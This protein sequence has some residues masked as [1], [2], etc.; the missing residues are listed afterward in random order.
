M[1]TLPHISPPDSPQVLGGTSRG[2]GPHAGLGHG[3]LGD[4]GARARLW[5]ARE[6]AQLGADARPPELFFRDSVGAWHSPVSC[7]RAGIGSSSSPRSPRGPGRGWGWGAPCSLG[8]A[9]SPS[10]HP[11]GSP[12]PAPRP[13]FCLSRRVLPP[14]TAPQ[15]GAGAGS[16]PGLPMLEAGFG[17]QGVGRGGGTRP[18]G[19]R[20]A[21]PSRARGHQRALRARGIPAPG[22]RASRGP[23]SSPGIPAGSYRGS[24]PPAPGGAPRV[25]KAPRLS[26][27]RPREG[28]VRLGPP[29][30]KREPGVWVGVR[31]FPPPRFPQFSPVRPQFGIGRSVP[32]APTLS[33]PSFSTDS[34]KL[35]SFSVIS[36]PEGSESRS[37]PP[38][39]AGPPSLGPPLSFFPA[40]R[41]SNPSF[42]FRST[43]RP[44]DFVL[45]L[46]QR[47]A[48]V[49]CLFQTFWRAV[50]RRK[51][52]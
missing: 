1:G 28:R 32:A 38:R 5:D 7:R 43:L 15:T 4:W 24:A 22:L 36:W 47:I 27:A 51:L 45:R 46:Y 50:T 10:E 17:A 42:P 3:V 33:R 9:P 41:I 44:G 13:P 18:G 29:K 14:G 19:R 26:P 25:P 23:R 16:G 31:F 12:S 52:N 48:I 11:P 40:T 30:G 39:R 2:Q 8:S 20:E 35:T 34:S 49:P 21:L 37:P 6:P